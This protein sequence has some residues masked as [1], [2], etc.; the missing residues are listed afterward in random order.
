MEATLVA[1]LAGKYLEDKQA[2]STDGRGGITLY[3][4]NSYRAVTSYDDFCLTFGFT[5][6]VTNALK[7]DKVEAI[8]ATAKMDDKVV[9]TC[10][11]PFLIRP[12]RWI[13]GSA[14]VECFHYLELEIK[15]DGNVWIDLDIKLKSQP[16]TRSVNGKGFCCV[17]KSHDTELSRDMRLVSWNSP[18]MYG[19]RELLPRRFRC[20]IARY[21]HRKRKSKS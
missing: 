16:D 5:I 20:A 4:V 6:L 9:G 15:N 18:I 3:H 7:D 2:I 10:T 13:D 14:I 19:L 1:S 17:V 12:L 11:A 8:T 21:Y